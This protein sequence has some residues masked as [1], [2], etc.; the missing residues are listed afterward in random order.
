MTAG[1]MQAIHQRWA[2]AAQLSAL[3][4]AARVSTGASP[5]PSLPRAVLTKQSDRPVA[6][7]NDGSAVTEI[8]VRIEVFHPDYDAAAAVIQQAA[9]QFDRTDFALP[10]SGRVI[11]MRRTDDSEQQQEDGTWRMAIDFLC[12]VWCPASP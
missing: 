3:L 1:V 10:Q 7:C 5:N 11:N 9:V 8:G 12:V 2:G 6:V 4:P